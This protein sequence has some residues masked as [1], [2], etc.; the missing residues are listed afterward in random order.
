MHMFLPSTCRPIRVI[1]G[2]IFHIALGNQF[3][4]VSLVKTYDKISL[5]SYASQKLRFMMSHISKLLTDA[6]TKLYTLPHK[7]DS[8]EY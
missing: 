1:A 8:Q 7:E 4:G 2:H 6:S 5:F 3:N